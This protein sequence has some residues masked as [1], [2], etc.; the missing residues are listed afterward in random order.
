MK[1]FALEV[2]IGCVAP[3][4]YFASLL[5]YSFLNCSCFLL[6]IVERA[7]ILQIGNSSKKEGGTMSLDDDI[8]DK[9]DDVKDKADDMKDKANDAVDDLRDKAEEVKD[10]AD[11]KIDE[12]KDTF[13]D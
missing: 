9:F 4:S 6:S 13:H 2:T 5:Y 8:K 3:I 1:S 7:S 12:A 10:D 11:D